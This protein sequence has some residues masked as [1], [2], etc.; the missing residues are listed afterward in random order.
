MFLSTLYIFSYF[1]GSWLLILILSFL[2]LLLLLLLVILL[3][4][5][6]L[7]I[8]LFIYLFIHSFM[9]LLLLFFSIYCYASRLIVRL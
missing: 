5:S 2:G 3:L 7:F 4:L 6:F 9:H 1:L 8:Y